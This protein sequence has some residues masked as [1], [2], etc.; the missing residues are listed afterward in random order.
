MTDEEQ[1]L[2][3]ALDLSY[4]PDSSDLK[5]PEKK[6]E[7]KPLSFVSAADLLLYFD[8]NLN[9]GASV[10]YPWQLETL[11]FL[12]A[13]NYTKER[14]LYF[15]LRAV[16]G[17]GKDAFVIAPFSIWHAACKIRS[18]VI[19]T[20]SSFKQLHTQTESYIRQYANAINKNLGY[21]FFIIKRQHIICP[22]TG[23]EIIMF[24]TDEE[25]NVEGYHPFPDYPNAEM[26]IITNESKSISDK[27][28]AALRRCNGFNRWVEV[29][30]P[31]PKSGSFYRN[32]CNSIK[33]PEP[34][35]PDKRYQRLVT[36]FDCPHISKTEVEF[37]RLEMEDWLFR[38]I[39]LGEF[40]DETEQVVITSEKLEAL[41]MG[42]VSW[43]RSVED[44]AGGLDLSLGGDETVLA[45]R[46]GNKLSSLDIWRIKDSNVLEFEID[47]K[48]KDRG[49]IKGVTPIYTDVGGLGKP[50][51][52][53]LQAL[54]WNVVG[55]LN[56]RSARLK[57]VY[58]N[59]GTE[60]W[61]NLKSLVV[62]KSI[63]LLDDSK[64]LKQLGS[65]KYIY[66]ESKIKLED[67]KECDE[68]PDRADAVV[69]C[70][71]DFTPPIEGAV[72]DYQEKLKDKVVNR[73]T[74]I[75]QEDLLQTVHNNRF[76][77]AV[78]ELQNNR[79]E[80]RRVTQESW[81]DLKIKE[82]NN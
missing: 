4:P 1:Q 54:G 80:S 62:K 9:T 40:C 12:S 74:R 20:S 42:N 39:F 11:D 64:L 22:Y 13:P 48:L 47:S 43:N 30:S 77:A 33:H 65:R 63:I 38:N 69:L 46:R 60:D 81:L 58:L 3:E 31:G 5:A 32:C 6:E 24:V 55:I 10:L 68:S 34:Y 16:N 41:K 72:K 27:T 59:G 45:T 50:I 76:V 67:K 37:A 26:V 56:N 70:F 23:S 57:Q 75:T 2:L 36:V 17:S 14:P 49:Y 7:Y 8:P 53:H 73:A 66:R 18:R 19:I 15:H 25:G 51:F 52:Q 28:F 44:L 82:I 35:R 21:K 78:Q 79:I 29:S 61:F 71:L